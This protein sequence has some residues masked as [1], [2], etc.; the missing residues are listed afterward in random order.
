LVAGAIYLTAVVA[1]LAV[2]LA[3]LEDNPRM[4][5]SARSAPAVPVAM[6]SPKPVAL[7][8]SVSPFAEEQSMSPGQLMKRWNPEIAQAAKRFDVPVSWIRAVM[9]V[10]SGGRT[11]L[12]QTTP[13]TSRAGAVGLMQLMPATYEDIRRSYGLG[14]DRSDPRDNILAGA[15]YLAWLRGKYGYPALFA[16]YNDGPGHLDERLARAQLL[17]LETRSYL[18]NV[19]A[20]IANRGRL[21]RLTRPNG[22]T[23]LIDVGLVSSIRSALP[24][25]YPACVQAVIAV[26]KLKQGVCETVADARAIVRAHGGG[27]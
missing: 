10:E 8:P 27:V 13:I 11:M 24:D 23:V 9:Q 7:T 6:A 25:E 14:P 16:A 17:P 5:A 12:N 15:A 21:A 3:R 22:S 2:A 4:P 18:V 26:G 1:I 19:T 20:A